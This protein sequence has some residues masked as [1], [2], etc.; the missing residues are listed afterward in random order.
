ML[1]WGFAACNWF[2]IAS[3]AILIFVL[4]AIRVPQEEAMMLQGFGESY[5][6]Y[7]TRTG[8]YLPRLSAAL[9]R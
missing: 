5:R 8:R 3:G 9:A 1:G 2:I 4:A 6:E 7:M